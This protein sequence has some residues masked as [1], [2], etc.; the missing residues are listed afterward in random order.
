MPLYLNHLAVYGT[1][2]KGQKRG[3][4]EKIPDCKYQC[5]HVIPGR[6]WD[7]G[8]FPGYSK[9]H[10]LGER[11]VV[12][13]YRLPK[14]KSNKL[15]TI[16]SLDHIEGYLYNR[17]SVMCD[18]VEAYIYVVRDWVTENAIQITPTNPADWVEWKKKG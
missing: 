6:L 2:R 3:F 14:R 4:L 18:G 12:S 5:E 16:E 15:K 1:L 8:P 9:E 13:L 7:L 11:V 17:E 10:Q